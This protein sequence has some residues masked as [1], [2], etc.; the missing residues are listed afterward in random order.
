MNIRDKLALQNGKEFLLHKEGVFWVAYEESAY[1]VS[2]VKKLKATKKY[3]KLLQQEVVSVGFPDRSL[4]EVASH[5]Q[6]KEKDVTKITLQVENPVEVS[7]YE[8]WKQQIELRKPEKSH[9]TLPTEENTYSAEENIHV[10]LLEKLTAFKLH[11]ATPMACMLFI[12][13]LQREY[14]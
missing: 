6:L 8:K 11:S 2:Q 5:F 9:P 10:T 4:E 1:Y 12:E 3:V 14:C 7:I 13:E